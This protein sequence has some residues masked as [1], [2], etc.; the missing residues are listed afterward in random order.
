M[1]RGR[2]GVALVVA[3][4]L[5][6]AAAHAQFG[7]RGFGRNRTTARVATPAD[8]D[9]D[10]NYCRVVYSPNPYGDGGGWSTDWPDADINLSIRLAELTKTRVSRTPAGDP[11]HLI[12]RMTDDEMFECPFLMM[13]EVGTFSVNEVEASRL[14]EH[15]LKGGFLWVD[16]FWGTRAWEIWAS[17]IAKVLPP[18]QYPIVDLPPDH[19]LFHTMSDLPDGVPQVPSINHWMSTGGGTSERFADS[20]VVHTRG[21]FDDKGRLMV[22]MTHNTDVSDSWEREGM[23]PNYFLTFSVPGYG[24]A[25]NPS[26][27]GARRRAG[28]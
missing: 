23:D 18:E 21:I 14:R 6:A 16:D 26:A 5:V 2:M 17:E 12:V 25:M 1:T 13:Q 22:L 24:V 20:A 10:F 11:N 9:G 28:G 3:M 8:F 19:P 7:R 15:L 4:V 27:T